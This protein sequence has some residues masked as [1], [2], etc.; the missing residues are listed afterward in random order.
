MCLGCTQASG[1][2]PPVLPV[3]SVFAHPPPLYASW[4]LA[5]VAFTVGCLAVQF[6]PSLPS[7]QDVFPYLLAGALFALAVIFATAWFYGAT[8]GNLTKRLSRFCVMTLLVCNAIAGAALGG[9]WAAYTGASRVAD[10]WPAAHEGVDIVATGYAANMPTLGTQSQR[11]QFMIE[12]NETDAALNGKTVLLSWYYGTFNLQPAQ[13][14]KLTFRAKQ[15][16]GGLNPGGFDYE[17]WLVSRGI[18]ATGYIR[19]KAGAPVDLASQSALFLPQVER[20]RAHIRDRLF[21]TAP[22]PDAARWAAAR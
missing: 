1:V 20:L 14:Y 12:S 9:S 5:V 7:T 6:Q 4:P 22:T 3:S 2:K 11:V 17:L 21:A 16:R 15:R 8:D 18:A 19:D 13:R 10:G